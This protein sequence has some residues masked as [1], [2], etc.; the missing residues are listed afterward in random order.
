MGEL[1]QSVNKRGIFFGFLGIF[2]FLWD[3]WD[4]ILHLLK[5][6]L[7]K[8]LFLIFLVEFVFCAILCKQPR[9]S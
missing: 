6:I 2:W 7:L 1:E 5:S 8:K 4:N 9:P 3:F